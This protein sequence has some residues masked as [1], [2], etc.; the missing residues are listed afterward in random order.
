[1]PNFDSLFENF[2]QNG[3]SYTEFPMAI[4]FKWAKEV[5]LQACCII[6]LYWNID[7][8]LTLNLGYPETKLYS[9]K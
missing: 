9:I 3:F 8:E 6:F 5:L 2:G 4:S 1:M 7:T